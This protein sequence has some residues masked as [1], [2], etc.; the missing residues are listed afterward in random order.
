MQKWCFVRQE[1]STA[2]IVAIKIRLG[3][4]GG[5]FLWGVESHNHTFFFV[6]L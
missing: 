4:P 2:T 5:F 6:V 1:I 3:I